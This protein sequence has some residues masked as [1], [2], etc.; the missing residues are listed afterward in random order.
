M[1]ILLI[2]VGL[3]VHIYSGCAIKLDSKYASI[4]D[5]K[6]PYKGFIAINTLAIDTIRLFVIEL[7]TPKGAIIEMLASD[8]RSSSL[9]IPGIVWS[10]TTN[11]FELLK[12]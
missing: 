2:M 12:E 4:Y 5:N 10:T 8:G 3:F 1:A 9:F 6:D 7:N 11:S